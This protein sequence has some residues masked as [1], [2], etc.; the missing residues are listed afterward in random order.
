M[1]LSPPQFRSYKG[2]VAFLAL[3]CLMGIVSGTVVSVLIG[4]WSRERFAKREQEVLAQA[5]ERAA[6]REGFVSLSA[7]LAAAQDRNSRS[8]SQEPRVGDIKSSEAQ[9]VVSATRPSRY[10]TK[11]ELYDIET[12]KI[13]QHYAEPIDSSWAK[14]TTSTLQSNLSRLS[15]AKAF[16]LRS[17]DC[18]NETCIAEVV[19]P[20]YDSAVDKYTDLASTSLE[21]NCARSITLPEVTDKS[22]PVAVKVI[23]DCRTWKASGSR[24]LSE[25][26]G[27]PASRP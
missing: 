8:V 7:A 3:A 22:A 24:F 19:W 1:S 6:K 17:V 11:K 9:K 16:D 12:R 25:V 2:R 4:A 13:S 14:R 5:E 18:R 27:V 26:T 23:F 15:Q 20:T 21:V 10:P